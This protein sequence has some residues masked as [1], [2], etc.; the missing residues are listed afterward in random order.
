MNPTLVNGMG[1]NQSIYQSKTA[2]DQNPGT[3]GIALDGRV[4]YY[5][6]NQTAAALTLGEIQVTATVTPNHHD[7][8]VTAAADFSA[9]ATIVT[10]TVGATAIA[11][12]EYTDG[13]VFISDGTGQGLYY[14]IRD[15]AGNA[16]STTSLATLY[17]PVVTTTGGSD[18]MSLVRNKWVNPQ[19]SN[20]TVSE[21]PVGIGQVTLAA[22]TTAATAT[23]LAVGSTYGWLQTWGPCPVLCDEAVTAEGQAITIGTGVVGAAEAD[24]TATTVSQEFIIGYNLTPLVDTE[25]QLVDLR[26]CA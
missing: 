14:K 11:L 8:T 22:A 19:Q 23:A 24:D 4:W 17:D 9:G 15:H 3:K 7:Q 20:T 6:W 21:I 5:T 26:I 10:L 13:W 18:T 12:E 16:G 2:P 1:S 25:F